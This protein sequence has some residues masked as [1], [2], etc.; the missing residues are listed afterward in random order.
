MLHHFQTKLSSIY[1][2]TLRTAHVDQSE[3]PIR[4]A[5]QSE[6]CPCFYVYQPASFIPHCCNRLMMKVC[7]AQFRVLQNA[8]HYLLSETCPKDII[9]IQNTDWR[10]TRKRK[11]EKKIHGEQ[12]RR[13]IDSHSFIQFPATEILRDLCHS[14]RLVGLEQSPKKKIQHEDVTDSPC[15]GDSLCCCPSQRRADIFKAKLIWDS[16]RN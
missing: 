16:H 9:Q 10:R 15:A 5:R 3:R 6:P 8:G 1:Y 7:V 13:T 12:R 14:V 4:Q 11:R 2:V